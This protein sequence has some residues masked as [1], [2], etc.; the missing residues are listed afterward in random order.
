MSLCVFFC[1]LIYLYIN[2]CCMGN[3]VFCMWNLLLDSKLLHIKT[4]KRNTCTLQKYD[5]TVLLVCLK[6]IIGSIRKL[7][8]HTV[9]FLIYP[10]NNSMTLFD[11]Q[12]STRQTNNFSF[13]SPQMLFWINLGSI[14]NLQ[15]LFVGFGGNIFHGVL[16]V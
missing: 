15:C 14:Q 16:S 11:Q 12:F 1:H 13:S 10:C 9:T 8:S 5:K 3:F 2:Y 7:K 6:W 4:V